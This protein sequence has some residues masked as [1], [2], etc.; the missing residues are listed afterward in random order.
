MTMAHFKQPILTE[1][2]KS[3][4]VH[5]PTSAK[6]QTEKRKME[7]SVKKNI[8]KQMNGQATVLQNRISWR[9]YDKI[10]QTD[11][12]TST[13]ST[14]SRKRAPNTVN[15]EA[16]PAK[17]RYGKKGDKLQLDREKLLTEARQWT[18][19]EQTN[20]SRKAS[21]YGLEG[22]NRGQILRV[23]RKSRDRPCLKK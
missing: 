21:E 7:S 11:T 8:E 2:P 6:R 14:P 13:T 3:K 15:D 23:P 12:L 10:R 22:P 1:T 9:K 4:L 18:E 16:P 20:W 17:K 5:R 19:N